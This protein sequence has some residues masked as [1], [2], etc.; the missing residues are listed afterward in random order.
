MFIQKKK[1][2]LRL[3]EEDSHISRRVEDALQH[4]LIH[5]LNLVGDLQS[6]I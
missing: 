2:I 1:K 6:F 5:L 3:T 4:S